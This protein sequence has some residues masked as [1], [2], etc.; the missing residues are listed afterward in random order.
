MLDYKRD[1]KRSR[2]GR[3]NMRQLALLGAV[4]LLLAFIAQAIIRYLV[5]F[6]VKVSTD[7]MAPALTA[8]DTAFITYTE[9]AQIKRGQIYYIK[10]K[11]SQENLICRLVALEGDR[12]SIADKQVYIN[13]RLLD[14]PRKVVD[15]R[16]L[17]RKWLSRD[18]LAEI[19]VRPNQFFCLFDNHDYFTD[20]RTWG[21]MSFEQILGQVSYR[22]WLFAK[23]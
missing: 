2:K 19:Q 16:I 18:N 5:I 17:P 12:I 14:T 6:P 9:L 20:S 11:H 23:I 22:N 8:G 3:D 10:Q 13:G 7:A 4:A 21:P 1:I 15:K